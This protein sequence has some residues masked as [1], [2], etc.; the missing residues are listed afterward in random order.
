MLSFNDPTLAQHL[1]RRQA[2]SLRQVL[3]KLLQ[4]LPSFHLTFRHHDMDSLLFMETES[5]LYC[6][7]CILMPRILVHLEDPRT[8]I[9]YYVLTCILTEALALLY[10]RLP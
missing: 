9:I 6:L 7:Y 8:L 10:I 3:V 1:S 2:H 4:V 5:A